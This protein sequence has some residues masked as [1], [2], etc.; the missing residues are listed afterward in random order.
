MDCAY[1]VGVTGTPITHPARA[2]SLSL[3]QREKQIV[4]KDFAKDVR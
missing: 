2:Q 1:R 3:Q 4:E